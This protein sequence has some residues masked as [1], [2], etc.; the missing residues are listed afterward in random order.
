MNVDNNPVVRLRSVS[1]AYPGVI[2]L[3]NFELEVHRGTVTALVGENGAGKSTV[4]RVLSGAERPTGGTVEID[5]HD[6]TGQ[7]PAHARRAG[8]RVVHQELMTVPTM[9]ALDNVFLGQPIR[10]FGAFFDTRTMQRRYAELGELLDVRIPPGTLVGS[11]S[12]AESQSVEIMRSLQGQAKVLVLD[13]PTASIPIGERRRLFAVVRELTKRGV[14]VIYISHDLDEVLNISDNVAVLRGG[15]KIDEMPA[16]AW[17]K[18]MLIRA[19]LGRSPGTFHRTKLGVYPGQ[20]RGSAIEVSGLRVSPKSAELNFAVRPGEIVGLAGLVGSGRSAILATL[21]GI[22]KPFAGTMRM[23]GRTVKWPATPAAAR[24]C[25]IV[26]APEDRKNAGL[27]LPLSTSDNLDLPALRSSSKC[28]VRSEQ[29]ARSRSVDAA[30]KVG[31]PAAMIRRRAAALSGGNQQKVVLGKWISEGARV[32]LVDEPTR[33]VDVGAK[34]EIYGVLRSLADTGAA[35]IFVSS[36]LEEILEHADRVLAV[37]SGAI[38]QDFGAIVPDSHTLL[39]ALFG[40]EPASDEPGSEDVQR[41][42][43]R[44]NQEG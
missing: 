3:R 8:V 36:E 38:V 39:N 9:T 7:G 2:A 16:E 19:M 15:I 43:W 29:L 33:G 23:S 32:F 24:R 40:Q 31:L 11:L 34:Q 1:R 30:G 4:V 20:G 35:V 21:A 5:G 27:V 37:R 22:R 13:E 12:V 10:R 44:N 42:M 41:L 14:A 25:G 28:F 6:T 18:P 17:T 26:L